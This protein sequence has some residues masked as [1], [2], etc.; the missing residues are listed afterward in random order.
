MNIFTALKCDETQKNKSK[1]NSPHCKKKIY[2]SFRSESK[3]HTSLTYTANY[4]NCEDNKYL[5]ILK[6]DIFRKKLLLFLIYSTKILIPYTILINK[7]LD[8]N[9][10]VKIFSPSTAS[11][12]KCTNCLF[13]INFLFKK[14]QIKKSSINIA[15]V[16]ILYQKIYLNID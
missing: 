3:I 2:L 1:K 4:E 10:C 13:L 14:I 16:Y 8:L 5:N 15:P 9:K 6:K 11:K 12:I 7:F